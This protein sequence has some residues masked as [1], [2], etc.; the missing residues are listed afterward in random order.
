MRL[1]GLI[2]GGFDYSIISIGHPM[3]VL[4]GQGA[5]ELGFQRFDRGQS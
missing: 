4:K 3:T 1:V 5:S 2:G